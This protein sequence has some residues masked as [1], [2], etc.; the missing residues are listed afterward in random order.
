MGG[1][2]LAEVHY[3]SAMLTCKPR[4]E[5]PRCR[6]GHRACR[7]EVGEAGL[8]EVCHSPATLMCEQRRECPRWTGQDEPEVVGLTGKTKLAEG[9]LH[10]GWNIAL[11]AIGLYN[12]DKPGVAPSSP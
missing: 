9:E 10:A 5:C 4:R 8:V 7:A 11:E 1:V 6:T 3:S 12:S 2:G